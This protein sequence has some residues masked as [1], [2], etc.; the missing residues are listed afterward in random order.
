MLGFVPGFA[1]LGIV[2]AADRGAAPR[3][4]ARARAGGVAVGIAGVQTGVYP[5]ETPGGWQL[6]GRTPVKPFDPERAEPFLHERRATPCSSIQVDR[7]EF[8]AGRSRAR[9]R[10]DGAAVDRMAVHRV[11][12]PGMLT[13]IQDRGR[14]GFRRAAFRWPGPMDPRVASARE[15]DRRATSRDAATLEVTLDRPR[16]RVRGRAR[17]VAVPARRSSMSLDGRPRPS[18]TAFVAVSAGSRLRFGRAR[19]RGA[20]AYVGFAGGIAVAPTLG[21]RATHL[22]ERDGRSRRPGR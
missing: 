19:L 4:A 5:A 6:I 20:R 17:L 15:R 1:Y 11:I 9:P 8:D 12:K 16:A 7:A 21:S 10:A 3:D 18:S 22:V 13:T 2:D 14:W